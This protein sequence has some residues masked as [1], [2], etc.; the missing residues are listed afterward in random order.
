[1]NFDLSDEQSLFKDAIDKLVQKL[2]GFEQRREYAAQS[3]GWSRNVWSQLA[4]QGFLALP[5]DEAHGG[6]GYGPVE[7]M[8]VMEAVGRGLLLEPYLGSVVAAGAALRAGASDVQQAEWIPDVAAGETVLALA[9][10]EKQSR[11]RLNDVAFTATPQGE[12][13]RLSGTKIAV[14]HGDTANRLLVTARTSGARTDRSGI[15]LFL[16]DADAP[17]VRLRSYRTQDGVRAADLI[18]DN[19]D[20]PASRL[21]GEVGG[22]LAIA[23]R[24]VDFAIAALAAEAVGCMQALLDLTVDYLKQRKQFGAPIG[25]FQALQHRTA[26]M[27][28]E[29]EQARSVAMLAALVVNDEDVA[30]RRKTLSAVKAQIG[31]SGRIVGELAVQLHGGIGVTEEYAVGHYFKRLTMIETQFGDS[32]FHIAQVAAAGGLVSAE[33]D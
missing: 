23:E 11:Y 13:F 17:G 10:T 6:L 1:M 22:G 28:V 26:E 8:L 2:Y 29:L 9:T 32:D 20:V 3:E 25:R 21:I 24:A 18:L 15:S 14:R 12:G 27:L 31:R 19:V 30:E 7:M 4:E 33:A 16:I 5:F